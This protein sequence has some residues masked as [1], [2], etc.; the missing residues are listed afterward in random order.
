MK[1]CS[2]EVG[3][4]K[5]FFLMC[6]HKAPHRHWQPDAK[7]AHLYEDVDIPEPAT[8]NDDYRTRSDAAAEATMRIPCSWAFCR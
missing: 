5:P 2:F 3:L 4:D 8:F 7:H 6:H 1:L